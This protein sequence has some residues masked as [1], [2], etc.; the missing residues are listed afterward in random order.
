M[1]VHTYVVSYFSTSADVCDFLLTCSSA[2]ESRSL[3]NSR[4]KL[5]YQR[6][7]Q[8]CKGGLISEII[9]L[10]LKSPHKRDQITINPEHY[11]PKEKILGIVIFLEI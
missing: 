8:H 7:A 10:W 2:D 1:N 5:T 9:S 4:L 11:Q 6:H 3:K